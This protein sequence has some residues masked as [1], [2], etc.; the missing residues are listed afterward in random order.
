MDE[1][2]IKV[3]KV[4]EGLNILNILRFWPLYNTGNLDGVYAKCIIIDDKFQKLN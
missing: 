4:K 1:P 3:P 2:V